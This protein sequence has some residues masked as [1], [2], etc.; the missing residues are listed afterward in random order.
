MQDGLPTVAESSGAALPTVGIV[1]VSHSEAIARG[2]VDLARQMAPTVRLVAAGGTETGELGTSF[3][4]VQRAFSIADSGGGIVVL[5]DLGSSILTADAARDAATPG[6][7]EFIRIANAP[8]VEGGV[9]AAV[10]AEAGSSIHEVVRAAEAMSNSRTAEPRQS[11]RLADPAEIRFSRTVTLNNADG[12]HARPASEFV[13][14]ANTFSARVTVNG[15][16]ARSLLSIMSLG[17]IKGASAEIVSTDQ[18][19]GPAVDAL[20]ALVES[21]FGA[22][23][24]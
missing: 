5:G 3:T 18:E 21:G 11:G 12:L 9:A 10:A 7:R 6:A 4:K 23:R 20:A 17:L 22:S 14:L 15:K 16:D 24:K 19:G 13:K 1:F 8:L 2:L